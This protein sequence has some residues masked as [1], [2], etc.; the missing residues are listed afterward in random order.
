MLC[1]DDYKPNCLVGLTLHGD[2]AE[3]FREEEMFVY[4]MSSIFA[5]QGMVHDV[6]INKIPI[7]VI[8]ERF[9]RHENVLWYLFNNFVKH[10]F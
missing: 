2:G 3:M 9:M 8:P 4:S 5:G 7:C 10:F 6:L 1:G